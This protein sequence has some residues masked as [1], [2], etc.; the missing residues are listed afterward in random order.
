MLFFHQ[1]LV[2]AVCKVVTAWTTW[3][4]THVLDSA[5]FLLAKVQYVLTILVVQLALSQTNV[6]TLE[7]Q[8]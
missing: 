4:V 7:W 2:L 3:I 5:A 1:C 6:L 8:C